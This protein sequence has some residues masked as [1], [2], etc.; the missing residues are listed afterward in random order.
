M[1]FFLYTRDVEESKPKQANA[2]TPVHVGYLWTAKRFVNGQRLD[3]QARYSADFPRIFPLPS[4]PVP[5]DFLFAKAPPSTDVSS[6]PAALE[7]GSD[8]IELIF[9]LVVLTPATSSSS[10]SCRQISMLSLAELKMHSPGGRAAQ[11]TVLVVNC[12]TSNDQI[13]VLI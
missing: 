8:A 13:L 2:Q 10:K 4:I 1:T 6:A 3:R 11:M 5:G 12:V 7:L 9:P